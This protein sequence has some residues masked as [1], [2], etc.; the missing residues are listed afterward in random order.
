MYKKILGF[1]PRGFS[2]DYQS[3]IFSFS[4]SSYSSKKGTLRE[5]LGEFQSGSH[6]SEFPD[7]KKLSLHDD[8]RNGR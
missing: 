5:A 4:L 6:R 2:S 7:S 8:F 3:D 1:Q